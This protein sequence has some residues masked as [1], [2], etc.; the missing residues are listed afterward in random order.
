MRGCRE[1]FV[2]GAGL[3]SWFSTYT[4]DYIDVHA[5]QKVLMLLEDNNANVRIQQL[6]TISAEYI[7][8]MEGKGIKAIDNL[9]V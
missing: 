9:N 2:A 4:Q 1:I 6:I 7:A 3:Y 5:Y 8:V